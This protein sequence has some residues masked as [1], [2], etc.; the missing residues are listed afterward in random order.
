MSLSSDRFYCS[1]I[2]SMR[3]RCTCVPISLLQE[4]HHVQVVVRKWTTATTSRLV[5]GCYVNVIT[6]RE[7]RITSSRGPGCPRHYYSRLFSTCSTAAMYGLPV[8]GSVS[9]SGTVRM[10]SVTKFESHTSPSQY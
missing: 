6:S 4:H 10:F 9:F 1:I 2:K 8:F 3:S 5:T 7:H